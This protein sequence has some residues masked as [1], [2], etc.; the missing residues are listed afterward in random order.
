M[1]DDAGR[2]LSE[3]HRGEVTLGQVGQHHHDG[4]AGV[5]IFLGQTNG[6]CSGGT[7]GD[8]H[9]QAFLLGQAQGH[10]NGLLV[11]HLL[12]LV[13]HG[14]V[15]VLGDEAGADALD[16]VGTGFDGFTVHGLGD[17]R[18]VG[19]FN[20][21]GFDRLARFILDVTGDAGDGATGAD[22]GHEHVNGAIA[23]VPDFRTG[24]LEV[25][26]GVG[27]IVE[28]AWHEVLAGIA[29]GDLLGLGD[30]TGHALGGFGEDQFGAKNG[31]HPAT[32][33]R[34]RLGHREDQLVAAG[35]CREGQ[36]DTGV[37]GRRLN[38]HLVLGELAA[39]LGIPDHVG[40]DPALDAVSRVAAFHL[41]QHG[42]FAV[43]GDAVQLHQRSVADGEAVV[44]VNA[45]HDAAERDGRARRD[46]PSDADPL[47]RSPLGVVQT[48]SFWIRTP[49]PHGTVPRAHRNPQVPPTPAADGRAPRS[50][51]PS[52]VRRNG[53]AGCKDRP[54]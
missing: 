37:S 29:V 8:A 42:G 33:D 40:A 10:G 2:H 13:D 9:Q 30:G 14:E 50:R 54:G 41:G 52:R 20:G 53:P 24:G 16:F 32:L 5:L 28:L 12:H 45:G 43:L 34:H 15:E 18:A 6:G 48:L 19:R 25:D 17:H 23:V 31:H 49:G 27:G 26:L 36:G 21:H 11:G 22:A 1:L 4:F 44:V 35:C 3:H 7:A 46:Q 47:G 39:L 38:D 51:Q